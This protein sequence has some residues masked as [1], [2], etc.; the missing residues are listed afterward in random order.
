MEVGLW[1]SLL[2][3]HEFRTTPSKLDCALPTLHPKHSNAR[4]AIIRV[5]R[6]MV[7]VR[8]TVR[9]RIRVGARFRARAKVRIRAR[10]RIRVRTDYFLT[11]HSISYTTTVIIRDY[12][13]KGWLGSREGTFI[14]SEVGEC[15]RRKPTCQEHTTLLV[16][17]I[18]QTTLLSG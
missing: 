6:A 1:T 17:A 5:I 16:Q 14:T 10:V 12:H 2:M 11:S 4:G 13:S 3:T 7:R 9:I 15:R 18:T 8:V